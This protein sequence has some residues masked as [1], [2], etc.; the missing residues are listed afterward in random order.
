M[1]MEE[2]VN[3][4]CDILQHYEYLH[5]HCRARMFDRK[6]NVKDIE[7]M[8]TAIRSL[9]AWGDV[10]DELLWEEQENGNPTLPVDK[11]WKI[12]DRHLDEVEK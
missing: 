6:E 8:K 11:V 12:I 5:A 2:I 7:A 4:L 10:K 3:Q 1:I 9:K